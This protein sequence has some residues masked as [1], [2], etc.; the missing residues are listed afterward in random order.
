MTKGPD[1]RD[2]ERA[3]QRI[4]GKAVR[5][6]LLHSPLLSEEFSADIY[7]KPENL[8]RMGAFKFRGA[9]N[10]VSA[11]GDDAKA[12][13]VACSSGN[14]AQGIAEA[15]R[16]AGVPSTIVMPS[17]APE[18]KKAGVLRC[19]GTI[20]DYDRMTEDREAVAEALLA[21][22]GGTMI[23]PY[24]NTDVIA[25]Q[26]TVG[27]E[28]AD[29]CAEMGIEPAAVLVPCGGGGLTAGIA[30]AMSERF[31][32]CRVHP[33]EPAGF[34]DYSRSLK[35]GKRERNEKA[36]GSVCDALLVVTPGEIGFEINQCHCAEGIV[37]DD[38]QALQAVGFACRMLK[39]VVEPGGAAALAALRNSRLD[40]A[41]RTVV[42]VLSGG[43]IEDAVLIRAF[44]E[45]AKA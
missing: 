40:V 10:A 33:V 22:Q 5:T 14:H 11:L 15:A 2:I 30:L 1:Y 9:Y 45:Y 6:P 27:L 32:D 23:H 13:I 37:I 8:Q 18:I 19:G 16:L 29:D 26:G 36:G 12:G 28:I 7:L 31:S 4:R 24:N 34:D 42:I 44:E 35:T 38:R 25:G 21:D 3:A 41:G 43:N 39:L 17:D 20:V